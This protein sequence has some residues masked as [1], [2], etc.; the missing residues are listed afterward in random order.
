MPFVHP[1]VALMPD[2]HCG[3]GSA[4]GTVIPTARRRDPG[5]GRRRHRLRDDRRANHVRRRATST[6]RD[7]RRTAHARSRPRSRCRRATTTARHRPVPVHRGRGSR[8]S[9]SCADGR[10]RR[11]VALARSGVSSSV[12]SVAATTSSSCASTRQDRVWMF[13]HSGSRGVGNKIA[14]QAHQDRPGAVPDSG[15]SRCPTADLAYLAA[16]HAGVRRVPRGSRVGAA[17][18]ARE[19]RRDDGPLPAG[20]RRL[21]G[22]RSAT[23]PVSRRN[24]STRTTTTPSRSSTAAGRVADPQGR[25]R[26]P[27]RRPRGHPGLDGHPLLHRARARATP[28]DSARPRTVPAGG[29][30]A[31][32]RASAFTGR[33]PRRARCAASS[34]GTARSGST[35]SPTPTRTSTSSWPTPQISSR[36]STCCARCST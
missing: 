28:P 14:Q 12:R 18:R 24:G 1:H 21:D 29:S 20:A 30:P 31:P 36:W 34:T 7:L 8:S 27:R 32:R 15:T 25:H 3:K 11:P 2:A 9:R 23:R 16:G 35:R 13:L 26:R 33:R 10:R 5:G 19:P 6:S 4:V 22:R 17:V